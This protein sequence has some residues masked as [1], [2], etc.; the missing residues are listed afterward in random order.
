M[1]VLRPASLFFSLCLHAGLIGLAFFWQQSVSPLVDLTSPVIDIGIYTIGKPGQVPDAPAMP[2]APPAAPSTPTTPSPPPETPPEVPKPPPDMPKPEPIPAKPEPA[3]LPPPPPPEPLPAKPD[4]EPV[5]I[6]QPD[7]PKPPESPKPEP[8][9]PE[10]PKPEPPKAIKPASP[11]PPARPAKPVKTAEQILR[12]ALGDLSGQSDPDT[13][14]SDTGPGGRG[15]DGIGLLGSYSQSLRSRIQ[16]NWEYQGR[17]DRRNPT[18]LVEIHI[19]E[20]GTI[21]EAI[22]VTSS[23]DPAFDGSALKAVYDT[24]RVEPPPTP[25]LRRVQL[26]FALEGPRL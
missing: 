14:V 1:R 4:P 5:P 19:A 18:A 9:K 23:G 21:L 7:A 2:V 8:P 6:V 24:K 16:P 25:D 11:P 20:D 12:E 17:A 26:P 3:P 22:I 15:G 10:P 13:A